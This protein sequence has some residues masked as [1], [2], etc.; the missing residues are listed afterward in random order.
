MRLNKE[1]SCK[2]QQ[3]LPRVCKEHPCQQLCLERSQQQI[4]TGLRNNSS[5]PMSQV[6]VSSQCPPAVRR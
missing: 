1:L 4:T 5:G 6:A 2:E 3:G